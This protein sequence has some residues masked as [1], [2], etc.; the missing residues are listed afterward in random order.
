[1]HSWQ[2]ISYSTGKLCLLLLE[3]WVEF[4]CRISVVFFFSQILE[5]KCQLLITFGE[6]RHFTATVLNLL[7]DTVQT[8][9]ED[10]RECVKT[11]EFP[12]CTRFCNSY[13]IFWTVEHCLG[14][15]EELN[16][17]EKSN[18][19]I[20]LEDSLLHITEQFPLF[21]HAV[22]RICGLISWSSFTSL[23]KRIQFDKIQCGEYVDQFHES[24]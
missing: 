22:W 7:C 19:K 6:C 2:K 13:Y 21:A 17:E 14:K 20:K 24:C 18:I 10:L 8:Y 3:I 1:M 5:H 4:S 23:S 15:M 9:T 16:G 11:G 12:D